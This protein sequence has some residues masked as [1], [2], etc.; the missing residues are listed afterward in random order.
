MSERETSSTFNERMRSPF[1][2]H[3]VVFVVLLLAA[4][5]LAVR[6][7]FDWAATNS[8]AQDRLVS[9][10]FELKAIDHE[11]A[12]L[13]G[14]DQR[15]DQTRA[16]LMAFE[17]K[18]IPPN[19][20]SIDARIGELQVASGVHLSHLQYTQGKPDA[21]LTEISIDAGIS[22][23]YPAIMRFINSIERDQV[24]FIIRTM[25]LTGQQGGQVNLR[26]Q[27]STW[28]RPADAA[29][30][31]LPSTPEPGAAPVPAPPAAGREG[32]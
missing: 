31:G 10:Q 5:A 19:Y 12:P 25:A 26:L 17:Q 21:G 1:T 22:G 29:A 24:F 14:L 7:G 6:L 13:R 2:W 4:I 3:V 18:R 32:E 20:S 8:N 27:L 23:D 30:S 15:V 11:T 28:L 16:Q 9:R